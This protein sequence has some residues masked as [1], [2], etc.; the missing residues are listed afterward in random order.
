MEVVPYD[1][2]RPNVPEVAWRNR[3]DGWVLVAFS[4]TPEGRTKDVR[5]LDANPRGVFEDKVI[6]AVRDWQYQIRFK[7]KQRGD[8][9]LTQRVEVSWKNY[10]Y[11]LPHVD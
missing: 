6:A 1:T 10:P 2:R 4:V 11:N 7:G 9:V 3:I 8:L 5:V